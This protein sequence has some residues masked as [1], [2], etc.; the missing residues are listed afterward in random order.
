MRCRSINGRRNYQRRVA[1]RASSHA[2]A[3]AINT[4]VGPLLLIHVNTPPRADYGARAGPISGART[5]A[6]MP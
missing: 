5:G 6:A 3:R 2:D 1:S 4:V